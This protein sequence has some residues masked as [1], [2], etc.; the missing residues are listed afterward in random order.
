MGFFP[1]LKGSNMWHL[2]NFLCIFFL[3]L[4][5]LFLDKGYKCIWPFIRALDTS[6]GLLFDF[7]VNKWEYGYAVDALILTWPY[8]DVTRLLFSPESKYLH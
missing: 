4:L 7:Q 8:L 5:K 2:D 3:V 1:E 6:A